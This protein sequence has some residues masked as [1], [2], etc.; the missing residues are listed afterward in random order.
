MKMRSDTVISD[1]YVF[2]GIVYTEPSTHYKATETQGCM[3]DPHTTKPSV[4]MS[5][6]ITVFH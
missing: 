6:L 3:T 1:A 2:W 4:N 5:H